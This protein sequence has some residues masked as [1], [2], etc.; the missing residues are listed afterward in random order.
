MTSRSHVFVLFSTSLR[1]PLLFRFDRPFAASLLWPGTCAT[2][3]TVRSRLRV[4]SSDREPDF[5]GAPVQTL[6][7]SARGAS[8]GAS[9]REWGSAPD[10]RRQSSAPNV[11]AVFKAALSKRD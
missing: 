2:I 4:R 8:S 5:Q 7:E 3:A 9:L 6:E 11:K 10:P 1:E